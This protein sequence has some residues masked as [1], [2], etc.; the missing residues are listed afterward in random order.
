MTRLSDRHSDRR[1][2]RDH[3]N[4]LGPQV[5]N[6]FSTISAASSQY[7]SAPLA[8]IRKRSQRLKHHDDL[9]E[10]LSS[11]LELSF[12]ST[13][14]LNSPSRDYVNVTRDTTQDDAMDISPMPSHVSCQETVQ[15]SK[16]T[17]RPRAY[18]SGARMFGQELSNNCIS[19][20]SMSNSKSGTQSGSKNTQRTALPVEWFSTKPLER[21][22]TSDENLFAPP[23]ETISLASEDAM[24][25]DPVPMAHNEDLL[26]TPPSSAAPTI[27]GF[28]L[29]H[30]TVPPQQLETPSAG[31][32]QPKKRRSISP[33][34]AS[35]VEQD[36]TS[37][38]PPSS[39]SQYKLERMGS[40]PLLSHFNKPG[41]QGLGV[42]SNINKRPRRP[43]FS[44]VVHPAEGG[45]RSAYPAIESGESPLQGLVP[46]KL[47]L[48]RRVVSAMLPPTGV[49]MSDE[50]FDGPDMSSPAQA[51][52]K[53]QQTKTIRRRDGTEDFRPLTGA[54]PTVNREVSESPSA[55]FML[56]GF[57]DNESLGKI[58][59]CHRV[60]EDGLLRIAPMTLDTLLDGAYSA[61]IAQFHVI[62]CRF[63]YEYNGG[64]IPGAVNI[65][66]TAGVEE[67]L[68]AQ[69]RPKPCVSGDTSKKTVLVFHCE[70]S[71]KRAPT[72]AKHLRS[73]DRAMNN[74][75]YPKIHYPEVYILEGGYCAYYKHSASRCQ[76]RGYVT[77]DDPSHAL[78]RR[79]DLDQF[80]KA[81]FGRTK[82]YAYGDLG[83]KVSSMTQ[84][85]QQQ[86]QS[87]R[88]TAPSAPQL[89][90]AANAA[91]TRRNAL[92]TLTEIGNVTMT[93]D[94]ET[95]IGDSPCPPPTKGVSSKVKRLARAPITRA[96]TFDAARMAAY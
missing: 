39:P 83:S 77:M 8:P 37:S 50:S 92:S 10:F 90:A 68:L 28:N 19:N 1:R 12:A 67:F 4:S 78:S 69:H 94:E 21:A 51:Y 46:P 32:G 23:A 49:D 25:V 15:F 31:A 88:N 29:F 95:D 9:D 3:E 91:R 55:K 89:F 7:L 38:P 6:F 70:F 48:S 75:V 86:P 59:P 18:T 22:H 20:D 74:H 17:S 54:S 45:A 52:M 61:Q 35:R 14:S 93:D 5:M 64:H 47:G 13:M 40:G 63:E 80:R 30:S 26:S 65:N 87:K 82:S 66:T 81:K 73:K 36:D 42:P 85:Q 33:E 79:E 11:D 57:G 71:A 62:D 16:P 24:D 96:E 84:Q 41:L 60:R 56:A 44:A 2:K 58:L 43:V 53:R 34:A 72:I 76:P 27:T